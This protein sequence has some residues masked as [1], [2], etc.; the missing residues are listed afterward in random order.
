MNNIIK[1]IGNCKGCIGCSGKYNGD[2]Y[3]PCTSCL[4]KMVCGNECEQYGEFYDILS[5]VIADI[6]EDKKEIR[7]KLRQEMEKLKNEISS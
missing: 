4:I 1:K 2:G 7:H 6:G 5:T 3:C